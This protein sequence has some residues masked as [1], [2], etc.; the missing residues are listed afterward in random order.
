MNEKRLWLNDD[1]LIIDFPYDQDEVAAIKK[2]PGAKWDKLARVWR[3]PATSLSEI[4]DF[5]ILHDFEVDTSIMLFDE[6]KRLNKSFG[7]AS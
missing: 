1:H 4:R 7:M 5:A 3:A 2:I 6:P